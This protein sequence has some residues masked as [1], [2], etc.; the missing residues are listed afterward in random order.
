MNHL[1]SL[2]IELDSL[3]SVYRKSYLSDGSRTENSA[4]HSWHLAM[5]LMALKPHLPETIDLD[6]AL[7]LAL[8]HDV[9]EIGA[10]DLS[11]YDPNRAHKAQG[12]QGYLTDL[13][14]RHPTFGHEIL[15]LWL[16]YEAQQTAES[17]WVKVV[18]KLLP[19]LL[20]QAT[21]GRTWHEQKI[22]APM[23]RRHNAFIQTIA[24]EIYQWMMAELEVAI[25]KGWVA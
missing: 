19:F 3:K 13:A 21:Q 1:N 12:E 23:V 15:A 5:T 4:E 24:P 14:E 11:A 9:C 16:E 7:K 6:H 22:T 8:A 17:R 10:G 20:N 18:D 2:I 25:N